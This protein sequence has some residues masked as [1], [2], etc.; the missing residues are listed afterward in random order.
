MTDPTAEAL[1]H[2]DYFHK[3]GTPPL[4]YALL[5]AATTI[6]ECAIQTDMES[7]YEC[8]KAADVFLTKLFNKTNNS[9]GENK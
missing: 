2:S 3:T 7:D 8:I 5:Q 4:T 1:S 6:M 9:S